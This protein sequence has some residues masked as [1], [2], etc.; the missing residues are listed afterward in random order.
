[1]PSR[2]PD[3]LDRPP[4][5]VYMTALG[6]RSVDLARD[7][8]ITANYLSLIANGHRR[9]SAGIRAA[10]AEALNVPVADLFGD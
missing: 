5:L 2:R 1:M 9:P 7:A 3:A 4:L 6:V 8:G 10:L